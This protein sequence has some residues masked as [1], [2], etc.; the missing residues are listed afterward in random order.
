MKNRGEHEGPSA[1]RQTRPLAVNA[2]AAADALMK[3]LADVRFPE[4]AP[5]DRSSSSIRLAARPLSYS[6]LAN[7]RS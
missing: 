2:L 1:K 4:I 5:P 7:R 6:R 3:Q